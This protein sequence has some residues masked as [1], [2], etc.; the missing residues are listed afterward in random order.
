MYTW[1]RVSSSPFVTILTYFLPFDTYIHIYHG[2]IVNMTAE[3]GISHKDTNVQ[4]MQCIQNF[5]SAKYHKYFTIYTALWI[6]FTQKKINRLNK[7]SVYVNIL[8]INTTLNYAFLF[9]RLA[10]LCCKLNIL[11]LQRMYFSEN[12]QGWHLVYKDDGVYSF[13]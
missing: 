2:F 1:M 6:I 7:R 10:T 9:L 12:T 5:Y 4:S 11:M 3:C 8:L 13:Y